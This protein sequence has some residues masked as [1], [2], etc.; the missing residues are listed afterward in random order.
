MR[1]LEDV[2]PQIGAVRDEPRLRLRAEVAGEQDPQAAHLHP[3]DQ[4]QVVGLC[5]G[6]G[7]LGCRRQHLHGDVAD[8]WPVPRHEDRRLPSRPAHEGVV[9][10]GTVVGGREGP[11]RDD[12]DV[13]ASERAG[14]ATD[15]VGVEVG[16]QH[17]RQCVDAEPVE[18]AI[19]RADVRAGV[20]QHR[21]T[22]S[23]GQDERVALPDVAGNGH[24]A[25]GRPATDRLPHR[26]PDE[27]E[28]Q[29]HGDG[30]GAQPREAPQHPAQAQQEDGQQHRARGAG[31][32]ARGSVRHLC[33]AAGDD[34]QPPRRPAGDPDQRIR[35][36]RHGHADDGR[37][38]PEHGRCRNRRGGQQVGRQRHQADRPREAR[39]EG[40]GDRASRRADRDGV[41][42]H[43]P[44]AARAEAA[45]PARR[46]QHDAGGGRD[47]EGEA[48]IPRQSR[49]EQEEHAHRAAQCRDG[50]PRTPGGQGQQGDRAHGGGAD[51]ARARP[52]QHDEADEGQPGHHGLHPTVHRAS[53]EGSQ[54]TGE[55]DGDVRPRHSGEVRQPRP[56]EVVLE[57]RVHGARVPDDQPRQQA[58]RHGFE[59]SPRGRGERLPQA[60][61]GL[62]QA[63][64]TTDERR[65]SAGGEH[66]DHRVPCLGRRD[67]NPHA[68]ALAR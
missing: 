61:G 32:P 16:H 66:R 49:V 20:H 45:G 6:R 10:P 60:A 68:C 22:G 46:E 27:D 34:D 37:Q 30:Q 54:H 12:P 63:P 40:R 9:R 47:G 58:G 25:G 18:A 24:G 21:G 62:L 42:E 11:G 3:D 26:P 8:G 4:R 15:V 7:P 29:E 33:G 38:Q 23:H 14:Q 31:G 2:R 35:R 5:R 64:R 44:A 36:E 50:R 52:G 51:D 41:R 19:H 56:P 17:E 13:P 53:A 28:A 59:H 65:R 1:H 57:H 48:G 55:D 43:R 67:A 39:D